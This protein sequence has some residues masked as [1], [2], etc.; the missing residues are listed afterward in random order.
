MQIESRVRSMKLAGLSLPAGLAVALLAAPAAAEES[1]FDCVIDP[2]LVVKI[3]SPVA[4]LLEAVNVDRGDHVR[5][6]QVVARI[7]ASVEAATVELIRARAESTAEIESQEA[8]LR[9]SRNELKR[10]AK[11]YEGKFAPAAEF[12][13]RRAEVEV[14][15]RELV[16]V[17]L[18]RRLA[19]LELARSLTVLRQ[20]TIRSPID[21]VV[22]ERL[23]SAGE[24]VNPDSQ[25]HIMSLARLD[26]LHVETFL[27][28]PLYDR[29]KTGMTATVRPEE[30]IGG[31][32]AAEV[33][34]VD[35]V[36]D[37]SSGTFGVRLELDNPGNELPGGQRCTVT[38]T[39]P[40]TL[41]ARDR[42][43]KSG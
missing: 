21:G 27:P 24:F 2:A 42:K 7:E 9:F 35:Q 13:G 41:P 11:L 29:I 39:I 37:P 36:F 22:T 33:T 23:L 26:P 43:A 31:T 8:R 19:Q 16:R 25:T 18:Q 40:A 34:V 38:F 30:P 3:G 14:G 28:V 4:G 20:R 17:K 12:E 32:Y 15:E 6:D 10:I 1:V 5:R